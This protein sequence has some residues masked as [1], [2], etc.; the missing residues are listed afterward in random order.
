[1][2]KRYK[3]G[4]ISATAP[5]TSTSAATGVWT[6]TQ[7][8]QAQAAGTWPVFVATWVARPSPASYRTANVI[9]GYVGSDGTLYVPG[10]YSSGG[11]GTAT[12]WSL[13]TSSLLPTIN[14]GT[15]YRAAAASQVFQP[16]SIYAVSSSNI[17]AS[18]VYPDTYGQIFTYN[19][20]GAVVSQFGSS[21]L[22][23][24]DPYIESGPVVADSSGNVYVSFSSRPFS[25]GRRT[26]VTKFSSTFSLTPAWSLSQYNTADYGKGTYGNNQIK[27]LFVDSSS[28]VYAAG[29]F[30]NDTF[31][32]IQQCP[33]IWALSSSGTTRWQY[34]YSSTSSGTAY[35][36]VGSYINASGNINICFGI[37]GST[38]SLLMEINPSTGAYTGV[39][40]T[41]TVTS[42]GSY[43]NRD[44]MRMTSDSLGNMYLIWTDSANTATS[45][46]IAK[47]NS[48]LTTATAIKIT[49]TGA[50][51]TT[52]SWAA[53]TSDSTGLYVSVSYITSAANY[54]YK[55]ST[56]LASN[57]G[58][59]ATFSGITATIA[60]ATATL[61][62]NT[63]S[64]IT[65]MTYTA[66]SWL[67]GAWS[68]TAAT[69]L[70]QTNTITTA[71]L[72]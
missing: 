23:M 3:G 65:A 6:L 51:D 57:V 7:Q 69:S 60:S 11:N 64:D 21:G 27:K 41:L 4:V 71:T 13:N 70:P 8:M 17:W 53:V 29:N 1:M 31:S 10:G 33:G 14:W 28:N 56:E 20:S 19:S 30:S 72:A 61:T 50:T 5:T 48:G 63:Y 18:F 44:D 66:T 54:I 47:I 49:Q 38:S 2:S 62:T 42:G 36:M 55:L 34:V 25:Q 26:A 24:S 40:K 67:N 15:Y 22:G 59:T 68:N 58:K 9:Q 35:K 32:N 43:F 16:G 46:F 12:V 39:K 45:F 37:F 52:P